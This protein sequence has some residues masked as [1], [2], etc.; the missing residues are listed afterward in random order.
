MKV[1]RRVLLPQSIEKEAAEML[2][3]AGFEL[4]HS[5]DPKPLNVIPL[6]K[7]VQAM[8]LRTGF[9]VTGESLSH[10]DE[11]CIIART[12]MGLDNVDVVAATARHIVVTSNVG[13]N[14]ASVVEHALSL[15]L[16]LSKELLLM[17]AEVR[18]GNFGIRYKNLPSDLDGKTLGLVG[19]GRIG[20]TLGRICHQSFRMKILAYDPLLT[21]DAMAPYRE[22]VEFV[23]LE[24]LL[25]RSDVVS[26]HVPLTPTTRNLVGKREISWMKPDALIINTSRGGIIDESALVAALEDQEIGGAGLDVFSEEPIPSEHPLLNLRNL[27]LTPHTAALT[28]ECVLRMATEAVQCVIDLFNGIEPKNVANPE[29]LKTDRWKHLVLPVRD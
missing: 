19:F 15:M 29:V 11:L 1:S 13:V 22:W 18:K 25:A 27:I 7:D 26:I 6:L 4:V 8:I 10:A 3:K 23:D 12:G 9:N 20:S 17:D 2:E 16:A 21:E 5:P 24:A 28:K 14:T